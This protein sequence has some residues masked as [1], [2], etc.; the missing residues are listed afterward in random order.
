MTTSVKLTL[1]ILGVFACDYYLRGGKYFLI[2]TDHRNLQWIEQSQVPIVVR[3]RNHLQ[4]F[5][6]RIRHIAGKLNCVAD[7]LSRPIDWTSNDALQVLAS[8]ISFDEVIKTVHGGR[9]LHYGV[10][11]TWER[12][13]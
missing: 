5:N 2:E 11:Y 1:F 13:N 6:F 3:W 12:L 10:S 7:F 4:Q 9:Q 8:D